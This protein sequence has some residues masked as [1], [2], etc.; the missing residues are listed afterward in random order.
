MVDSFIILG[1]LATLGDGL[2]SGRLVIQ[3]ASG[4]RRGP[5]TE[6]EKEQNLHVLSLQ[7]VAS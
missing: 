5:H 7:S 6:R 4:T 2:S 1:G 3:E